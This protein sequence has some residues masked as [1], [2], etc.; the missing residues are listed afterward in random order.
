MPSTQTNLADKTGGLVESHRTYDPRI[1]FF[2]VGLAVLGLTLLG[3]LGYQQLHRTGEHAEREWQ[4]NARRVL[5]PGP[6]GNIYDRNGVPLVTNRSR[7]TVVLHVDELRTE[8]RR[9]YKVIEANYKTYKKQGQKDVPNSGEM[10]TIARVAVAQRY[11]DQVNKILGRDLKVDGTALKNHFNRELLI[12]FTVAD[13]LDEEDFARL[14]EK[15]PVKSPLEVYGVPTREYPFKSAAAHALGYVRAT[16]DVEAEGFPG[17]ELG[18]FKMKSTRGVAGMEKW[19]DDVLQGE[20]GGSIVRVDPAGYK[21]NPPLEQ[22]LPKKGKDIVSSLDIDLQLAAEEALGDQTGAAVAIDINTG[23]VLT[24]VSKPDYDLN[25]WY[26]RMSSETYKA[27]QEKGAEYN[28]ALN[29]VWPPGSTFKILTSIAGLRHGVIQPDQPLA[30]CDGAVQIG[31]R[32]FVCDNRNGRHGHVLLEGAIAHSCDIYYFEVGRLLTPQVLAAEARRFH[33]DRPT[34][35][36]IP[37][38]TDR[39]TIPDPEWKKAKLDDRWYPGDTANMSIGQGLVL[40]TPLDM[41]CFIASFARDEVFTKPTLIHDPESAPQRHER[42]GLTAAQHAAIV[43]GMEG[44]TIYGTGSTFQ[45]PLLKVPGV[46]IAGKTGTAQKDVK[47]GKINIAWF[48]CFAP[49]EKPEIAI[50]VAVEGDT[51]GETY[52]GGRYAAPVASA[53]LKKY[54]EKKNAGPSIVTGATIPVAVPARSAPR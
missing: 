47:G 32:T 19:F 53:I 21:I 50:A 4:Q 20:A 46:R 22:R 29:G 49:I 27:I 7:W 51:P 40:S 24:L 35:I 26:P 8:L 3:G 37:G 12:P 18:T 42:T 52:G 48:V 44:T 5:I 15:L 41:A 25:A 54:F 45:T 10:A 38:E 11:L 2:Y 28:Y 30:F 6:R 14:I 1:L 9:E 34:G 16:S 17:E 23:E 39:M 31:G 33:L 36:E 43:K 13:G